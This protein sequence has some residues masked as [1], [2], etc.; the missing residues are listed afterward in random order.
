MGK[1]VFKKKE[2]LEGLVFEKKEGLEEAAR[3]H[4]HLAA[5]PHVLQAGRFDV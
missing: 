5:A 1:F 3:P 2:G 4:L